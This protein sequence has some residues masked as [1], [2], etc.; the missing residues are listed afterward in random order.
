[1]LLARWVLQGGLVAIGQW[2]LSALAAIFVIPLAS[3][4]I[5]KTL[6]KTLHSPIQSRRTRTLIEECNCG[7]WNIVQSAQV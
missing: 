7:E 6:M 4:T 2:V 5:R 1:M 3:K